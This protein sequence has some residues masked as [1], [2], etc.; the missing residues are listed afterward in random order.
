MHSIMNNWNF[1]QFQNNFDHAIGRRL[2]YDTLLSKFLY[3]VQNQFS[4]LAWIT[5]AWCFPGSSGADPFKH[6]IIAQGIDTQNISTYD[7][8]NRIPPH[9]LGFDVH[10]MPVSEWVWKLMDSLTSHYQYLHQFQPCAV[11]CCYDVVDFLTNI[12]KR[13]PIARPLWWDMM[14]LLW[15]QHLIDILP[16]F[17]QLSMKYLTIFDRIIMAFD[18]TMNP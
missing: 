12:H 7:D 16:Q 8:L 13:H 11:R 4:C 9:H 6:G 18:C 2:N 1:C 10:E 3:I 5:I 15:I 17:L 14:C